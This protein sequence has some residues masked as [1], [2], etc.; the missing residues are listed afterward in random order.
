MKNFLL[1]FVLLILVGFLFLPP[2][3][4]MFAKDL[5]NEKEPEKPKDVIETLTCNKLNESIFLSYQNSKAYLFMYNIMGDYSLETEDNEGD[6]LD[7]MSEIRSNATIEYNKVSNITK[8]TISLYNYENI[9]E[10]LLLY[11]KDINSEIDLFSEKGFSCTK[12][13]IN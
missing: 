4:R 3:L 9:P 5:Y 13:S 10:N 7:I 11:T 12:N 2:G 8:F 1:Y 6:N